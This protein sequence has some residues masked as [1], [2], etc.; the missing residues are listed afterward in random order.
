MHIT[1]PK[2]IIRLVIVFAISFHSVSC[3][4]EK[5]AKPDIKMVKATITIAVGGLAVSGTAG[6]VK[7]GATVTIT[8]EA[9]ISTTVTANNDGSFFAP[10][11]R[12]N[13]GVGDSLFVTQKISNCNESNNEDITIQQP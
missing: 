10:F 1:H 9:E 12:S 8:D 6:S 11:G 3:G 5:C 2:K 13:A 4:K 7:P